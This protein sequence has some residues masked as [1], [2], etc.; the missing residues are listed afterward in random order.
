MRK[1]EIIHQLKDVN[2]RSIMEINGL[3]LELYN[4]E[5]HNLYYY[6][7][8][9]DRKIVLRRNMNEEDLEEEGWKEDLKRFPEEIEIPLDDILYIT[10][11]TIILR[12][13]EEDVK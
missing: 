7:E 11:I 10:P 4:I 9:E 3:P 8:N 6:K 1:L 12:K 13:K 5:F 2:R